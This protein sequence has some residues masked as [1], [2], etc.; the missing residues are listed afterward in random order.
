MDTSLQ[1][2]VAVRGFV[3]ASCVRHYADQL[4]LWRSCRGFSVPFAE[5]AAFE[6]ADRHED[7]GAK[8][9]QTTDFHVYGPSAGR[10]SLRTEASGACGRSLD[11]AQHR[12][13]ARC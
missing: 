10:I 2:F 8:T 3:T 6:H 12:L 1:D 11:H 4:A 7:E 5:F 13:L 9:Q